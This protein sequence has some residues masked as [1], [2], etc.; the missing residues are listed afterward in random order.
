MQKFDEMYALL[1]FDGSDVRAHYKRYGQWLARQAPE[2]MQARRAEAEMIFRRV[3]ITFAVYGD[4]DEGGVGNERLIPFDLVP[5]IIPAQE[6]ARMERGLVQRVAA[7][8][9]FTHHH[10]GK[11]TRDR[12][13]AS[14]FQTRHGDLVRKRFAVQ[15]GVH[16]FA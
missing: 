14:N 4:K 2:T 8:N 15:R 10:A 3:G 7:L 11:S 5:R 13:D 16:P 9:H 6:W 12:I 1:P